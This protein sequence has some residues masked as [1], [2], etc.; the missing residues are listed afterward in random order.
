MFHICPLS[1][2]EWFAVLKISIPVVLLDETLKFLSRNYVDGKDKDRMFG[3]VSCILM[4][5]A[6]VVLCFYFPIFNS[7]RYAWVF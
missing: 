3:F 6:F 4:W 7:A 2:E 1:W 5:F